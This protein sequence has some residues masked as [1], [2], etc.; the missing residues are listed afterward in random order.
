M[1]KKVFLTALVLGV[2]MS[3]AVDTAAPTKKAA[4]KKTL[5]KKVNLDDGKKVFETY[6]IACHGA[7]G[8]GDGAAA[9]AL[10]PKPRNFTDGA[11]MKAR[12]KETLRKVI[13][14]GGGSVGLSPVM[15]GWKGTLKEG[16]IDAVLAFVLS[17]SGNK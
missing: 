5:T 3:L 8:K 9:A 11:Y 1:L 13:S 10:N 17:L 7:L 15:A 6:C 4:T 14:E 12:P 16:E 2:G